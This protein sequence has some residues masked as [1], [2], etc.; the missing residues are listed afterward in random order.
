MATQ[1]HSYGDTWP[2]GYMA[3]GLHAYPATGLRGYM[4]TGLHGYVATFPKI[5]TNTEN[6]WDGQPDPEAENYFTCFVLIVVFLSFLL[7]SSLNIA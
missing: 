6:L 3:M 5:I 4:A 2:R 7:P 1:L